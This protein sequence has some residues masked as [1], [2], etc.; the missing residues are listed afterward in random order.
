[1]HESYDLVSRSHL[2]SVYRIAPLTE[3]AG[4]AKKFK[5]SGNIYLVEQGRKTRRYTVREHLLTAYQY[6]LPLRAPISVPMFDRGT[7]LL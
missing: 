7:A 4:R 2:L 5:I 6:C 1:M 3:E